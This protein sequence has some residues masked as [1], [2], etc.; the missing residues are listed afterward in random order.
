MIGDWVYLSHSE[1]GI[2]PYDETTRIEPLDL[3]R[4]DCILEAHYKPIPLTE[5]ILE[6]NG[7]KRVD[8][9]RVTTYFFD[10][11]D[12]ITHVHKKGDE[13]CMLGVLIHYVHE[14]QHG[15]RFVGVN[16]EIEP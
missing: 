12:H 13:I 16:K 3:M 2:A 1:D 4:D 14:L 11:G 15:L 10:D 8:N 5:E 9:E 6:K 7:F